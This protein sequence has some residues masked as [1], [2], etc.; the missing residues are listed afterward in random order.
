M[1]LEKF[2]TEDPCILLSNLKF[3]PTADM[4]RDEKLNALTRLTLIVAAGFYFAKYEFWF[5]F[6]I[7]AIL[8]IVLL[9]YAGVKDKS[10]PE[11]DKEETEKEEFTLTP[12]YASP[13][14]H[15]T[16][17]APLFSEE[18]QIYPPAYDIYVNDPDPNVTFQEP[19]NPQMYPY[20][21][22][23]TRTNLLPSDEYG[24][25]MLNGGP[26]QA[27]EYANS[28]FVRHRL[29][30]QENMTRLY[31]KKLARRFRNNTQDTFSPFQSY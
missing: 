21:Q 28:A 14:L 30:F 18:W 29:G 11:G 3:L 9:K 15:T 5:T 31:K 2:W 8:L 27:R 7:I 16:T 22:Y 19:L 23:L 4:T 1:S 10:A 26:R 20:G 13:D 25:H 6:L 24:T 17:L 12:T